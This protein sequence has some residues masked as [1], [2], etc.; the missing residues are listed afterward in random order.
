MNTSSPLTLSEKSNRP[1]AET[2][3][4]DPALPNNFIP[5]LWRLWKD[6]VIQ[7]AHVIRALGVYGYVLN[8]L[9]NGGI[10]IAKPG[11]QYEFSFL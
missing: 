2:V 6:G 11:A 8:Y 10:T 4:D 7:P 1:K 5:V 3:L 9:G